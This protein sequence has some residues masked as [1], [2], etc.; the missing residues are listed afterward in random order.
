M[1]IRQAMNTT[2]ATNL[3]KLLNG[4]P[5]RPAP[6]GLPNMSGWRVI[7]G[8]YPATWDEPPRAGS[9]SARVTVVRRPWD[10]SAPFVHSALQLRCLHVQCNNSKALHISTGST[11]KP[12][13]TIGNQTQS[14]TL[15]DIR[16]LVTGRIANTQNIHLDGLFLNLN[17]DPAV[18]PTI[19]VEDWT[20]YDTAPIGGRPD[21]SYSGVM[22]LLMEG[23]SS[24]G[25]V[26][27]NR[28]RTLGKVDRPFAI[29]AAPRFPKGIWLRDCGGTWNLNGKNVPNLPRLTI[30]RTGGT[31]KVTATDGAPLP[32][33]ISSPPPWAGQV[34]L[35]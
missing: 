35:T 16:K 25:P 20:V 5:W 14:F 32:N 10:L 2:E 18:A 7:D 21:L 23:P 8:R 15:V 31:A 6:A 4:I 30:Y 3:A 13:T 17:H 28:C 24:C 11:D 19:I 34:A 9:S 26:V 1:E 29:N 27:F 22:P 33:I 12:R